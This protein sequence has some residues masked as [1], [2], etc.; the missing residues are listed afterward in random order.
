MNTAII[1]LH[2]PV[3]QQEI[4]EQIASQIERREG[5]IRKGGREDTWKAESG[6]NAEEIR[7]KQRRKRKQAAEDA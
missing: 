7:G 1:Y 4:E 6:G 2:K 3:I 5:E